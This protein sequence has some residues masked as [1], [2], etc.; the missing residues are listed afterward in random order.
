M[1]QSDLLNRLAPSITVRGDTFKI[2]TYG[3]VTVG[4]QPVKAWCEAVVQRGHDFVDASD[5][6]TDSALNDTNQAFGRRFNIVSLRWLTEA[7]L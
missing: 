5:A 1:I 3:G 2:R 4:T 7:E 6:S